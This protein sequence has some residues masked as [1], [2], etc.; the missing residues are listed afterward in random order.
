MPRAGL[1]MVEGTISSWL[2]AEGA[3]VKKGDPI[4]EFENEKNTIEFNSTGDGILHIT[5]QEGDVVAVGAPIGLLAEDQAEYDALC[6]APA[7]AAPAPVE[8]PAAVSEA[9]AV[10]V[11]QETAAAD[12]GRV[13]ATGLAKK[14]ARQKGVDLAKVQG[15]GPNRR[16]IAQD[17]LDYLEAQKNIPAAA[18]AAA[19][20]DDVVTEIQMTGI[21]KAIAKNMYA[22]LQ[23]MAQCTAAVEVDVTELLAYRQKLVDNQE[24]L[25]CKV[26]VNDLLAMATVKMLQKHPTANAT[27]D[28]KTL[29]VHSAVNLSVAVAAEVGLMVPVVKN[30]E[31]MSLVQLH[32]AMTDVAIRARDQKLKGGEQAGGTFTISNVGM[33]PIDWSTPIINPPQV[34][35]LGFGRAVKKPAVVG[36]EVKVRSMMHVFLTFDHR[37]FDGLEVG[38]ILADMQKLLENPELITV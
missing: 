13:R 18:P 15:T 9:P 37:V 17:V 36:D 34:A 7:A 12:T 4:M 19:V 25:G 27:F 23:E 14:I 10:A 24:Y 1:T 21:R 38:R 6:I 33:F 30:C 3:A 11:V 28:G 26:T 20:A 8:A 32:N 5:A 22:S 29:F 2:V 35:I 16:I 31:R